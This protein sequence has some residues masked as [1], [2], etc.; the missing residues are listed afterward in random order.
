[1]HDHRLARLQAVRYEGYAADPLADLHLYLDDMQR[2][3]NAVG[4]SIA[5]TYF[6]PNVLPPSIAT[7]S[8]YYEQQQQQ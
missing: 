7:P 4:E 2:K 5:Q 3:I 1:M 8:R 6:V